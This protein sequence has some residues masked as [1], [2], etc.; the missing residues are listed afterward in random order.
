M[1][2]YEKRIQV[3][4]DMDPD[5]RQTIYLCGYIDG[6]YAPERSDYMDSYNK[7]VAEGCHE[8]SDQA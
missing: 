6:V 8:V 2:S 7:W 1:T 5:L 3:V 4:K